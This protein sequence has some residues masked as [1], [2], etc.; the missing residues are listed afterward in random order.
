MPNQ[1]DFKELIQ[2][3]IDF[4]KAVWT[5]SIASTPWWAIWR[6]TSSVLPMTRF[7]I[8][9]L[10]QLIQYFAQY[11]EMLGADK[12]ALVMIAIGELYDYL[13][14]QCFPLWLKA[15]SPMLKSVILS[16]VISPSI[17]WIVE[18]YKNSG[19]TVLGATQD[20]VI[21]DLF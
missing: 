11:N 8:E 17:D 6:K 5:D 7:L 18:K 16:Q 14:A 2:K 10:D 4:R 9:S 12:K 19:W 3:Y 15:V 1:V 20:G 21:K 13:S